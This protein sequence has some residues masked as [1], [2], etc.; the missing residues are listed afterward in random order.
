LHACTGRIVVLFF[1]ARIFSALLLV[2]TLLLVYGTARELQL[3]KGFALLLTAC[4]GLFPLTSFVSSYI[5]PDNLAFTLVSLCFYLTL[6]AR[7]DLQNNW[8]LGGLGLA[9]GALLLTK[10]HFFACV[11]CASVA[12]LAAEMYFTR[13]RRRRW[14]L[15]IL[16]LL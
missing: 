9:L 15:T 3:K 13:L 16:L 12:A 7:R 10:V 5:Q 14:L 4:V 11:A 1:G 2:C 8:L 6:A